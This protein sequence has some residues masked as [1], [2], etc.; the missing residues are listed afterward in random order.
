LVA[1]WVPRELLDHEDWL[2]KRPDADQWALQPQWMR[3]K[4]APLCKEL[5][6]DW[7]TI[8]AFADPSNAACEQ[9]ISKELTPGCAGVDA[10]T[11]GPLLGGL[12]PRSG[13]KHMVLLN[14]PFGRMADILLLI[15]QH[16]IQGVLVAPN[17]PRHWQGILRRLPV[18]KGPL[19]IDNF[20]GVCVPGPRNPRFMQAARAS[21]WNMSMYLIKW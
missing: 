3:S 11:C 2:S 6:Y 20:P 12:D 17:W 9:F 19:P 16:R 15:K 14:G 1:K 21:Q 5:G 7:F 10:F 18:H 13:R 4:L 8:D